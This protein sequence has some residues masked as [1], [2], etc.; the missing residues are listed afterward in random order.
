MTGA[1]SEIKDE[2]KPCPFCGATAEVIGPMP[3]DGFG[4]EGG[5]VVECTQCQASSRVHFPTM[6]DAR[7]FAIGAWNRRATAEGQ[8]S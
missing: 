2:L 5:Y 3:A 8:P 1:P 6:D 4:N 7:P